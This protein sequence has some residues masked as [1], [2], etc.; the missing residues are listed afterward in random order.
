MA[1]QIYATGIGTSASAPTTPTF[2]GIVDCIVYTNGVL[3]P[4]W[5]AATNKTGYKLYIRAASADL[6]SDTYWVQTVPEGVTETLLSMLPDAS[7]LLQDVTYYIGIRAINETIE[8]SN[9]V[10]L[11]LTVSANGALI[12]LPVQVITP[13]IKN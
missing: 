6:F 4:R 11:S 2:A 12:K 9:T 7:R 5:A 8:D 13:I 10:T 3:R 1:L